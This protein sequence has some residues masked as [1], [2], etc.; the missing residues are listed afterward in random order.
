M[1]P[2]VPIPTPAGVK[3]FLANCRELLD[4]AGPGNPMGAMA[5]YG[6]GVAMGDLTGGLQKLASDMAGG[7]VVGGFDYGR[8]AQ[9]IDLM[10]GFSV[11]AG[12]AMDGMPAEDLNFHLMHHRFHPGLGGP[13]ESCDTCGAPSTEDQLTDQAFSCPP[14]A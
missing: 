1:F 5:A 14:F 4:A 12:H 2:F 7:G 13:G 6:A 9:P 11:A 3:G 8:Q 10:T